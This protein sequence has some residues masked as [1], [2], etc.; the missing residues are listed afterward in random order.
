MSESHAQNEGGKPGPSPAVGNQNP[1]GIGFLALCR[2]DFR[3]YQ[4]NFAEQGYWAIL[5][6]R[7]GN[8]RMDIRPKL[9]RIP[10]SIVYRILYRLVTYLGGISLPQYVRVGRR[11][12][13]WHFGGMILHAK[14]IGDDVQIRQNTTFGL[15]R[16]GHLN[17][18]PVI[19][20]RVDIGCGA[21][22]LGTIRVGHDS[23]I[24][25][26]AVVV[27][28]VPPGAT[29]VGVPG[30]V[31]KQRSVDEA[32]RPIKGEPAATWETES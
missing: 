2:E 7:Y 6:H 26:N 28:D 14:S 4:G 1:R 21:C 25:A 31:I 30:R 32:G 24:G 10:F 29:V 9:V 16:E 27:K 20:D 12:R 13:I 15:V 19:E 3:T 17:E 5:V 8:W 22:I 23:V 11:V 18:F